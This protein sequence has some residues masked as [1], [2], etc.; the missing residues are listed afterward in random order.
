MSQ[1]QTAAALLRSALEFILPTLDKT[2][3]DEARA[4]AG[5]VRRTLAH[6][7][8]EDATPPRWQCPHCKSVKVQIGLPAWH[9]ET[10]GR[11]TYVETDTEADVMW[12]YCPECNSSDT[13]E[14]D[15]YDAEHTGKRGTEEQA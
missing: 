13:G 6:T 5:V 11:L 8:E 3:T 15:H 14:P 12:W 2:D 9:T 7:V 10:D 1:E 4:A